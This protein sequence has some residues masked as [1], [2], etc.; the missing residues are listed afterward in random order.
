MPSGDD[1]FRT[2]I[3]LKKNHSEAGQLIDTKSH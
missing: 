2:P 3:E 1:L